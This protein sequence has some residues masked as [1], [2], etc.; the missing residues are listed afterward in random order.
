M[1]IDT[2]A[3]YDWTVA[4]YEPQVT[5]TTGR[6]DEQIIQD[7]RNLP[8]PAKK[9]LQK[10]RVNL[11]DG[12]VPICFEWMHG[13]ETLHPVMCMFRDL[14]QRPSEKHRILRHNLH[15]PH[16]PGNSFWSA[17]GRPPIQVV[18]AGK[19]LPLSVAA[20]LA[21]LTEDGFSCRK[22]RLTPE[23]ILLTPKSVRR[24]YPHDQ[25]VVFL[26]SIDLYSDNA[27]DLVRSERQ[28]YSDLVRRS[29]ATSIRSKFESFIAKP[30]VKAI[31][32]VAEQD[33]PETDKV[34][35]FAYYISPQ[36]LKEGTAKRL[37]NI[38]DRCKNPHCQSYR[39]Y[40]ERGI[41]VDDR[42]VNGACGLSGLQCFVIDVGIYQPGM[43]L[44]R[45]DNDGNYER[46]NCRWVT[47]QA[48]IRN[49]FRA[50]DVAARLNAM[51]QAKVEEV[52]REAL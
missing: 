15:L 14:G 20:K 49:C 46:S 33:L 42:W 45:I 19:V 1:I 17:I 41:T 40:G 9:L 32:K 25:A 13:T 38:I 27:A 7:Y 35:L 26:Q 22:R 6:T 8:P 2:L 28:R 36:E 29:K 10:A 30:A 44:D 23:S 31:L 5:V 34:R 11:K 3:Y 51:V 39:H 24:E 43:E 48:N 12:G 47:R 16:G 52:L 50:E 18:I 4:D 37:Y 21:G